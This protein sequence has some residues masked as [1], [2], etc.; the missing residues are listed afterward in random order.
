MEDK[1]KKLGKAKEPELTEKQKEIMNAELEK[2]DAIR[3][4]IS[5]VIFF[6]I[7]IVC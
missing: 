4:K 1:K 5:A 7:I 6:F 2:E 3:N